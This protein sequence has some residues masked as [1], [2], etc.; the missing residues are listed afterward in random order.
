VTP[1]RRP[2]NRAIIGV[3]LALCVVVAI[4]LAWYLGVLS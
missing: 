2:S 4:L 1:P 3:G